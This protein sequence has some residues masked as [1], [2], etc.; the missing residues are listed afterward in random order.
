LKLLENEYSDQ[1]LNMWIRPLQAEVLDN[2]LRLLAPNDYAVDWLQQNFLEKMTALVE[3]SGINPSLSVEIGV[4]TRC[5]PQGNLGASRS[6]TSDGKDSENPVDNSVDKL[7]LSKYS[8]PLSAN[9]T[10]DNFI[11]GKSNE[12]ACAAAQQVSQEHEVVYNPLLIYGDV[13]LGKTHLM[14]A[15]G[16]MILQRKK[17]AKVLYLHSERFV[18]NM[19]KALQTNAIEKF[20]T[21]YRS[22]DILLIDDIQ[23]F[24][25]KEHSQ[26]EFFHTFNTLFENHKQIILTC[27]R[28]PKEL[29]GLKERLRSRFS[30][31]LSVAVESPNLETRVA[32][33]M[34]K[35]ARAGIS[36]PSD[37]AFFMARC[38]QSNVRELEGALRRVIANAEFKRKFITLDFAKEALRD[39]IHAQ[40]KLITIDNIQRVVAEYFKVK[41]SELLVKR[42]SRSIVRPRQLAMALAKKLTNRSL[43][44][45]G[46]AFG[47]RDHTTVL[48]ADRKIKE[49]MEVNANIK[50]DYRNLLRILTD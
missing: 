26:E 3:R 12:F 36:L 21:I 31:G 42:R 44:E 28:Y 29:R 7:D 9:F 32:I 10:F 43:P 19:V 45:I 25:G 34:S 47:G 18:A 17:E 40:D 39:L 16:H 20:Q 14:Q 35:A 37:V 11:K 24:V 5:V 38:I 49:L 15:V 8:S 6:A 22:A 48:H 33:L 4:G 23:F 1:E 13:G 30:W 41:V 2:R 50:D 27:D 46:E